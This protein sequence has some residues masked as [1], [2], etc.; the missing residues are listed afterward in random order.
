M[1]V[2]QSNIAQVMSSLSGKIE[3]FLPGATGYRLMLNNTAAG[4]IAD[5]K[6]RIHVQGLAA[7]GSP[8]GTYVKRRGGNVT[9]GGSGAL[10]TELS[11]LP[12]GA[13]FGLGWSDEKKF[14]LANILEQ[15]Y[16]K[17]IWGLTESEQQKSISLAKNF[18][19]N[20]LS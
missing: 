5:V 4:V 17:K 14:T 9:L 20:A 3:S 1:I 16:G 18:A 8:I 12:T 10:N 13:G 15:K 2:I 11:V 6:T 7:D 19:A